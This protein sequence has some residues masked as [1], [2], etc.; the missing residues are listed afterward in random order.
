MPHKIF[1]HSKARVAPAHSS[2]S[3]FSY[4]LAAPI[5]VPQSRVIIDQ[6]HIPNEFPTIHADNKYV[7]LEETVA[8]NSHKRKI[9]LEEGIYDSNTLP[10]HITL[11]LNT[12]TNMIA[13]S[14]NV[15][16][17]TVTGK[18]TIY[19]SD[20]NSTYD[21]WPAEYLTQGLWNPLNI[22]G[23]P[24]YTEHDNAYDVLG[25][26]GPYVLTGN[27][28]NPIEGSSHINVTPYHTLYIHSSLGTQGDSVGPM[29]SSSIIRTVCLD[30]PVG[31]YV[32]DRCALPFDYVTV[33]KGMIRQLDFRLTDWRGRTVPLTNSWSFSLIIVP[34]DEL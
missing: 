29:G 14:Y 26:H 5:E 25:F 3:D 21:L 8:G 2:H 17:N 15:T 4:Q 32:H 33:A 7:Y 27:H 34:E 12:G 24:T 30:Q 23:I 28:L 18:L 16:F 13:N 31:R 20:P 11:A 22:P 9:A 1:V 19:S 10:I 6:V